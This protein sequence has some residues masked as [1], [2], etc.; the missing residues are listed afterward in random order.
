MRVAPP[1]AQP[2]KAENGILTVTAKNPGPW[3][4]KVQVTL[5]TVKKQKL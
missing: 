3:G 4:N 1:D 2:A 5:N